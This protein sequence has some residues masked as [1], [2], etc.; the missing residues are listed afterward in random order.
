MSVLLT[1][2]TSVSAY[3]TIVSKSVSISCSEQ[4]NVLH[5]TRSVRDI[6][7]DSTRS[8]YSTYLVQNEITPITKPIEIQKYVFDLSS[9]SMKYT[10]RAFNLEEKCILEVYENGSLLYKIDSTDIHRKANGDAWFGS[11]SFSADESMFSYVAG[12]AL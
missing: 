10:I 1:S 8:Y 9:K 3:S 5:L 4:Q 2:S 6:E 7:N 12:N 11:P